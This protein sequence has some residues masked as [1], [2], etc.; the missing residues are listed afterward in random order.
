MHVAGT[1][2]VKVQPQQPDHP[3]A[4]ASGLGRLSLDKRFH[5]PLDGI[6]QGEMLAS[7]DGRESGAYVA[8][9]KV[10]GTLDGRSGSFVLMHSAV[11]V[12]GTPQDWS[13]KVVHDSGTGELA[14]L[15]GTMTIRIE[16]GRH[17][18]D[19]EYSLPHG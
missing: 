6:S 8:L 12:R 9:E 1:F 14:G 7:G 19:L 2:D 4:R 10:T 17:Y 18:Y 15:A 13:V 3:A 16:S 5:G 11:M